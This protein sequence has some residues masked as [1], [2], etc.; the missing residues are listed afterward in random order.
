M[1]RYSPV[2]S[3]R[4]LHGAGLSLPA[5]NTRTPFMK[6]RLAFPRPSAMRCNGRTRRAGST[7]TPQSGALLLRCC[8]ETP[9]DLV[10]GLEHVAI[11]IEDE[12]RR[13]VH[14]GLELF[15]RLH[16]LGGECD[17]LHAPVVL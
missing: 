6:V 3:R 11:E 4:L 13:L 2:A 9:E 16:A 5:T 17:G 14:P 7:C 8:N 10:Q 1:S 12:I 15:F